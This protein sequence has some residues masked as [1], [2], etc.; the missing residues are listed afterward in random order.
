METLTAAEYRA[1]VAKKRQPTNKRKGSKAKAEIE[2]VLK[3]FGKP[4]V[5][6][7]SF[8]PERKW[9]FDFAIPEMKI[10]IEYEGLMSEKSRHTTITGFTN[11][12]EKYNAAQI[13]GWRVLRYTALNY[14]SLG[15]DLNN[16]FQSSFKPP[17]QEL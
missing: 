13:L 15:E 17:T 5:A 14:M 10:A 12:S 7:Y 11:D 1:L 6:E 9:R 16:L 3:L 4:Y 8:H 2:I